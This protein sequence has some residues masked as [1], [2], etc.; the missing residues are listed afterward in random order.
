MSLAIT[1]ARPQ[2]VFSAEYLHQLLIEK[3]HK[4]NHTKYT[5]LLFI[6]DTHT[7]IYKNIFQ[8]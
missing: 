4:K 8:A 3:K 1:A 6:Q 7:H 5:F 2:N